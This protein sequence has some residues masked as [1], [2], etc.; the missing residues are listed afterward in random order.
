MCTEEEKDT[1]SVTDFDC[2]ETSQAQDSSPRCTEDDSRAHI[3][4]GSVYACTL[5]A[6]LDHGCDPHPPHKTPPHT[7]PQM[8]VDAGISR[9]ARERLVLSV[10]DMLECFA[11]PVLLRQP[12]VDNVHHV[13]PPACPH[14]EVV[15][16]DVAVDETLAVDVLH[17][18]YLVFSEERGGIAWV[19]RS[20]QLPWTLMWRIHTSPWCV[21]PH[22]HVER[23]DL[24]QAHRV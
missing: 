15:G 12:I 18:R 22:V 20:S 14:K 13:A 4:T 6:R 9:C 17:P 24:A 21:Q 10:R 16:L 23:A 5:K 19:C 1:G 7:S 3:N 8:C 11:V 2:R